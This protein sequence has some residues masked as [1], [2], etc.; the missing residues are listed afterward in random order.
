MTFTRFGLVFTPPL[1]VMSALLVGC[2]SGSGRT[3]GL[4]TVL[5]PGQAVAIKVDQGDGRV[6]VS[7]GGP[8]SL[9][10][11]R[12]DAQSTELHAGSPGDVLFTTRGREFWTAT[13]ESRDQ[14][15]V[16]VRV[17]GVEHAE[18]TGPVVTPTR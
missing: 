6:Q 10:L 9:V 8:G 18:I 5:Q 7:S 4:S 12:Q 17:W 2:T 16:D 15:S 11:R 14:T 3:A 13:N 1:L